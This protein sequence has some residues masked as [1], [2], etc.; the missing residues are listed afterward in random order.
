MGI[1][2]SVGIRTMGACE[3]PQHIQQL[4]NIANNVNVCFPDLTNNSTKEKNT[5]AKATIVREKA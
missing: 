4:L 2:F 3:I 1:T 5:K